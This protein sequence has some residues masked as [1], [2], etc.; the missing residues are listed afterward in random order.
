MRFSV[1]IPAY[2]V[3]AYLQDCL[4]SVAAQSFGDWEAIVVDDGSTDGTGAI[5]ETWAGKDER[6]RVLRQ[7]NQGL[8]AA[9]N[10]GMEL[11]RGEY[12]LFLDGD[13][14]LEK[15]A[16]EVLGTEIEGE[17]VICFGGR[18][19]FEENKTFEEADEIAE[20]SYVCGWEY[21]QENALKSRHFAFVSVVMRAYRRAFLEEQGL[22][23]KEGI[24]HE[25]NLFTPIVLFF[26]GKTRVVCKNLYNYRVREGSIMTSPSNKNK[27]DK[28]LIANKLATFFV[29]KDVP[30]TVVY[31]YITHIYQ[32]VFYEPQPKDVEKELLQAVEWKGY[33][34]VSRTKLRHRVLYAALRVSPTLF[35][36]I[37]NRLSK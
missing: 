6:I 18:R 8:S 10:A 24:Y 25:D 30:K 2:N 29:S 13:D 16:L 1:I 12:L 32:T 7:V 3:E 9:R 17:D 15:D 31:R 28:I 4:G 23:F 35:R 36:I 37:N 5:A 34:R 33:Y 14:W 22:Q 27:L 19:Y 11:A 21:Y 20:K 26:A